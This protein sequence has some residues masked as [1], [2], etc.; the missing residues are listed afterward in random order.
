MGFTKE[1]AAA[2]LAHTNGAVDEAA[3]RLLSAP[4]APRARARAGARAPA[5]AAAAARARGDGCA[6]AAPPPQLAVLDGI[7][8]G[9]GQHSESHGELV[10]MG[11]S[12]A[13]A[14]EALRRANGVLADAV[15]ILL[16]TPDLEPAPPP[17]PVTAPV[18]V[19]APVATP[20]AAPVAAAP[21]SER[22]AVGSGGASTGRNGIPRRARRVRP[23]A[24]RRRRGGG[25]QPPPRRRR[26]AGALGAHASTAAGDG[27]P[28]FNSALN[29]PPPSAYGGGARALAPPAVGA[30]PPAATARAPA[31]VRWRL[32]RGRGA[33]CRVRATACR[34]RRRR[35]R[36]AA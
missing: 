16:D 20:V 17:P 33:A 23:A 8:G 12:S 30:A 1:A 14:A 5:P 9:A 27:S 19:A 6:G 32:R 2:A 34:T 10:G 28:S 3:A 24:G 18:P 36:A 11:F 31:G 4:P 25:A 7:F 21:A 22:R 29:A 15:Q 13:S 26:H 35:P